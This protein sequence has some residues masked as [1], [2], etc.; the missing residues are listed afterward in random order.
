MGQLPPLA[1]NTPLSIMLTLTA[2]QWNTLQ[3]LVR[4]TPLP[5]RLSAPMD[6]EITRQLIVAARE[7][8]GVPE[9]PRSDATQ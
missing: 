6:Q 5:L 7:F 4:E 8:Q 9:Y 3:Q 1:A 2:E